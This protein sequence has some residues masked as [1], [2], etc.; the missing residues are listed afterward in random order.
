MLLIGASCAYAGAALR[1]NAILEK[2][3]DIRTLFVAGAARGRA[4]DFR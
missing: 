2:S 3:E 4:K 1:F